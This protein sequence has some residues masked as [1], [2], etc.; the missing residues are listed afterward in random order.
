MHEVP[1][2]KNPTWQTVQSEN[3]G[4]VHYRHSGAQN[5]QVKSKSFLYLSEGQK[6]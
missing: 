1:S 4:P 3:K 6:V 2:L 5:V